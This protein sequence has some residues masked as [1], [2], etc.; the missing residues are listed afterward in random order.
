MLVTFHCCNSIE[1]QDYT[2]T[3][4]VLIHGKFP[5]F[6]SKPLWKETAGSSF[7]RSDLS[8]YFVTAVP[9]LSKEIRSFVSIE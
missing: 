4:R 6:A 8:Y 2:S 9:F 5:R 7:A 3:L 1:M